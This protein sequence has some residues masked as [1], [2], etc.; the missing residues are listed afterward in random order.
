VPKILTTF[1]TCLKL[2]ASSALRRR[3]FLSSFDW[4]VFEIESFL[5]PFTPPKKQKPACGDFETP[6]RG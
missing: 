1:R 5:S 4:E 6:L 3:F 2:Q